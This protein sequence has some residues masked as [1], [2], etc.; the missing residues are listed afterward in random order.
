[1][2][3]HAEIVAIGNELVSG[4]TLDTN[5]QW[6]AQQLADVG[7]DA[8]VHATCRDERDRIVQVLGQAVDRAELVLVT[9]GL[10]PTQDDLTRESL[11]DLA[12]VELRTDADSLEHVASFFRQIGKPMPDRNRV[13]AMFPAG[14]TPLPNPQGTAPGIW[15]QVGS[16]SVAAM[17]GV[18]REMKYMFAHEVLP[19]VR[20]GESG[21]GVI[22][23]RRI[24]SFGI[25]ESTVDN[26]LADLTRRGQEPEVGLTA[27]EAVIT[28]RIVA[29]AADEG[30]ARARLDG[31]ARVVRE[32]LKDFV[33]GE[34]D[35]TLEAAVGRLLRE[36]GQTLALAESCTG[37]LVGHRLTEVP[38]IS[39]SLRGGMVAY[40]NEAK[41]D[42]LGVAEDL[43][44]RH[45]AVSPEVASAMAQGARRVF[46][47]DIGIGITGIAGPTGGTP[48]KPV[49]LVYF[50]LADGTTA[51]AHRHQ[52]RGD[53]SL[54]KDR[55][56]KLALN[57]V[58]L[59]LLK[60]R[61]S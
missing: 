7:I 23:T 40:A 41:R 13:Q 56:A 47:A 26:L 16:A 17:P 58:R 10:G 49:G 12:G 1:M 44:T 18:P 29:R 15:M 8:H 51:E 20:Q 28:V 57:L 39:E 50:G 2:P 55:S 6:L 46:G 9:G 4:A 27:K 5:S 45:G 53:R 42:L 11:A 14:S 19:R 33:F 60:S 37:G 43:L 34:D 52:F 48:D 30:A 54:V 61:S 59:H 22:L 35:D 3:T 36:R 31:A 24:H 25:G 21:R 32:R 38:G